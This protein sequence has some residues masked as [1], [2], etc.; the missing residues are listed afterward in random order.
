MLA[1]KGL[2][3]IGIEKRKMSDFTHPTSSQT[4]P[5]TVQ[6]K[7]LSPDVTKS[8]E[9]YSFSTTKPVGQMAHFFFLPS[10]FQLINH[11]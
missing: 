2:K 11:D 9:K 6:S 3:K 4:K 5:A 1:R 10:S 8:K 7:S